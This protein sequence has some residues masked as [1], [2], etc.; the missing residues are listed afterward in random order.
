MFTLDCAPGDAEALLKSRY[1]LGR[2]LACAVDG[3][4]VGS[5]RVRLKLSRFQRLAGL[6]ADDGT[7]AE[8]LL[9]VPVGAADSGLYY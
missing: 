9:L 3:E 4:L 2:R 7:A 6:L 8:P 1:D 5:T